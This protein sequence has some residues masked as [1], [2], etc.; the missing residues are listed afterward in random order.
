[1]KV[2][3]LLHFSKEKYY[4][5]AVQ[6][7]WYYDKNRLKDVAESYVFH[8]PKYYGVSKT[9]LSQKNRPIDTATYTQI[10]ADKLYRKSHGNNFLMTVAGYGTG[11]SHRLVQE[12]CFPEITNQKRRSHLIFVKLIQISGHMLVP[13]IRKRIWL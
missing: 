3:D 13:S 2:S 9:D 5:G 12:R 10:I 4:N 8:G 7:E 1:M 11:K 6:T